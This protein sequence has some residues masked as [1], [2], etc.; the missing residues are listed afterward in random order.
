MTVILIALLSFIVG[1]WCGIV[2]ETPVRVRNKTRFELQ[3]EDLRREYEN[4]LSYDG[5]E[6]N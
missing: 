4:F 5:T 6:Q 1:F 2:K 3:A